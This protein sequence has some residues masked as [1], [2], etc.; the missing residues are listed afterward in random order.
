MKSNLNFFKKF[1]AIS[2]QL[3]IDKYQKWMTKLNKRQDGHGRVPLLIGCR[4]YLIIDFFRF[5][6]YV[7]RLSSSRGSDQFWYVLN[8]IMFSQYSYFLC[9]AYWDEFKNVYYVSCFSMKKFLQFVLVSLRILESKKNIKKRKGIHM[10]STWL[11][12]I[13]HSSCFFSDSFSVGRISIIRIINLYFLL[14]RIK[15][16]FR[17]TKDYC[18]VP[19]LGSIN[20]CAFWNLR[21]TTFWNMRKN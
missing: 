8:I 20:E 4:R 14:F 17:I 11:H 7:H 10:L 2:Q 21:W 12:L 9:V 13:P 6:V 3:K 18:M 19:M 15:Y 1:S 5:F 16:Y